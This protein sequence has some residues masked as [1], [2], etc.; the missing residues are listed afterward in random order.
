M[1]YFKSK[2]VM[3]GIDVTQNFTMDAAHYQVGL[4]PSVLM[5]VIT[6]VIVICGVQSISTGEAMSAAEK[7]GHGAANTFDCKVPMLMVTQPL[8]SAVIDLL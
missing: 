7:G 6:F 2:F 1:F 4:L 5:S 3:L 8:L